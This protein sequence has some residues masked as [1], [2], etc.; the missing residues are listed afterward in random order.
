M[1]EV[2][3]V[4]IRGL[5]ESY[6]FPYTLPGS[7]QELLIKPITTGQ[8]K[9]ILVYEDEKDPYVIEEALDKLI[10]N[11]VLT[12]DFDIEKIYLQDRFSLLLEIRKITKGDNYNFSFKCSKCNVENI[13]NV[14]LS[15]LKIKPF[16]CDDNIITISENLKFEVDF[17]TRFDQKDSI[18]RFNNKSLN[19]IEKQVEV[20]TG[21]FANSIKKVHTPSGIFDNI[22]FDDK[23]YILENIL[24]DVFDE[25]TKWFKDHE[26]GVEFKINTECISCGH[27]KH[28]EIP[29]SDFFV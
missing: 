29:L 17:P 26:F 13:K 24:G 7:G 16:S 28:M 25:F 2:K 6:E 20:Q 23:F 27:K 3:S 22:S 15:E 12:E 11:C 9:K 18:K 19:F 10:S 8:M 5:I 21:T 14:I 4:D 1:S